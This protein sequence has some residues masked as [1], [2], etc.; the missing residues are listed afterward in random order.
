[1]VFLRSC[2]SVS[3][4]TTNDNFSALNDVPA[5]EK[6]DFYSGDSKFI[7]HFG[8][9][10]E[11][12]LIS[13]IDNLLN[14]N[15]LNFLFLFLGSLLL[16]FN[17]WSQLDTLF[18]FAAP[19][20]SI[21]NSFDRPIVFRISTISAASTIVV[22]QPAN[23]GFSPIS[24]TIPAG[25]TQTVDLTPWIDQIEN[26][27]PNTVLNYGLR[28][29]AST[30]VTVYYEVVSSTC[31]CNP[32][33]FALKGKNALGTDFFIPAQHF[34]NNGANY[35]PIPYSSFDIV[36][37]VDNTVVSI[38]P[39]QN[40]VGHSAG[41]TYT[42][43]L[44]R[45]QTYSATATSQLA[46]QHLHGSRVQ[47]NHPIA[48]TVKDDLL[49]GAP[50]G[51]CADLAGDQNIPLSIVGKEYIIVRGF[52]NAPRDQ[53]FILATQN[54]T[55]VSVNGTIVTTLN[56]GQSYNYAIG[57]ANS[58]YIV[59][60]EPVYV[61]QLS[62]FGCEVG[63][64]VLPPIICT[65]SQNVAFARS[66]AESLFL[67]LLVQAGGEGNFSLNGN[68]GVITPANFSVVPGTANQWLFAQVT[69]PTNIVPA[70]GSGLVSNST[71]FF[72][73]GI[74]HGSAG[75]GCRYGY[76][77]DFSSL[78]YEIQA[79][80]VELC[81]GGNIVLTASELPNATYSWTGPNNFSA[82]GVTVNIN[83]ATLA[84]SGQYIV[85]GTSPGACELKSDTIEITILETA[86]APIILT[87]GPV[88]HD[89]TLTFSHENLANT[90]YSWTSNG[91]NLPVQQTISYNNT[92]TYT[93]QLIAELNGCISEPANLSS[94]IFAPP[95][96]T[97]NGPETVCGNSVNFQSQAF[98]DP[99]D[100]LSVINWYRQPTNELIGSG[101]G[102]TGVSSQSAPYSLET[103][104][105]EL[106]TENGCLASDTFVV[107]FYPF[108][109]AS[110]SYTDLCNAND[111]QF[112]NGSTWFGNA[113][114]GDEMNFGWNF[115]GLGSGNNTN[116]IYTFPGEGTYNVTL[117]VQSNFGCQDS[118]TISVTV[119]SIPT[120]A[121]A[122]TEECGQKI[123][124]VA[125]TNPG[126]LN[127]TSVNWSI[128]TILS[129][130]EATHSHL[131]TNGGNYMATFTMNA[132]NDCVFQSE[133]PLT[134]TPKVELP[135]LIIP[136]VITVNSDG[137]NDELLIDEV[138]EN[139]FEYELNIFNRW[140]QMVYQMNS[141]QNAFKG[142]DD[143]GQFLTEGVYF[144]HLKSS[145]GEK[146]GFITLVK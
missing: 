103:F 142:Q 44:Q 5:I 96:I 25:S 34:L 38:T 50:F 78:S 15:R 132:S 13:G 105:A 54:N 126:N 24:I 76:F 30:P 4:F 48:I 77:S 83:N 52:L 55:S 86:D 88:C 42:I 94:T 10:N 75:G 45:G 21:N 144:Y 117:N 18:W 118:E 71:H 98:T 104:V 99:L 109:T 37:T 111:I 12:C 23:P 129:V 90:N 73:M 121:L 56:Q 43:T 8:I 116:P 68:N 122:Y 131:F 1:L 2:F 107:T 41:Q 127:L 138:F 130:N 46:A 135:E 14:M 79:S 61:L 20:V 59:T 119:G 29:R 112:T 26:K 120:A 136:N 58:A 139:C 63:M 74:I 31:N 51:G 143:K 36:A 3:L 113:A 102:Q 123:N 84:N 128:P 57:E 125:V 110:F 32:E 53:V 22:D 145:Q 141:A 140:G 89:E 133:L 97:Y 70:A 87:N 66:T 7:I 134:V 49:A 114:P 69:I 146:H 92:G 60:S 106:E 19:E 93:V 65:G 35:N 67:I 39:S 95:N 40:V 17:S 9:C 33:I 100:P 72:H 6:K 101:F 27:P 62:G 137:I 82:Q 16:S 91:Q 11:L 28:L 64:S 124:L 85:S 80:D 81:Q 115:G 47:S 108:P